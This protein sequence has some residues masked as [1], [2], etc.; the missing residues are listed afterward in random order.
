MRSLEEYS[1]LKVAPSY[2]ER[3]PS[4]PDRVVLDG[5]LDKGTPDEWIKR[6]QRLVRLTGKVSEERVLSRGRGK[7]GDGFRRGGER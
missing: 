7:G 3:Y 4:V 6:D 2:L 1:G 5:P